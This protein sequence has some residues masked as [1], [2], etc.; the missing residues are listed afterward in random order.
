MDIQGLVEVAKETM[1]TQGSVIPM[2]HIDFP[3]NTCIVLVLEVLA[4]TQGILAQASCLARIAWERCKEHPGQPQSI[5]IYAEAWRIKDAQTFDEQMRPS[6][7]AKREEILS[8]DYW[9]ADATPQYQCVIILVLRDHKQRVVGFGPEE[10]NENR[11]SIQIAAL[12]KGAHDAQR[13][14]EEVLGEMRQELDA[15]LATLSPA[16]R[17]ELREF[18][19]KEL[20]R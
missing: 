13:P 6:T 4:D 18:L 8:I 3:D 15:K 10:R 2:A 5:G 11:P 9:Q 17:A 19:E 14:D 1:L 16:Q 7:S 12:V 20:F